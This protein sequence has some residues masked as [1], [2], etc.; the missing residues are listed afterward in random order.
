MG[1]L[2]ESLM[3]SLNVLGSKELSPLTDTMYCDLT[4][5]A[6]SLENEDEKAQRI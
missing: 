4:Y 2:E 1:E 6:T 5:Q 3:F